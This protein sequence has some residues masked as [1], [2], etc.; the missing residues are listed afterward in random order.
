MNHHC[1]LIIAVITSLL[2]NTSHAEVYK[3]VDENGKTH[4]SDRKP[5]TDNASEVSDD[6]KN[7]NVTQSEPVQ[8]FGEQHPETDAEKQVR[9]Q[10]ER[11]KL[12]AAANREKQC[13]IARTRLKKI[14][15]PVYFQRPD[16][17][18]FE[19]TEEERAKK[20]Q[21]LSQ[22]IKRFCG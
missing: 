21:Q 11:E 9:R 7:V 12:R 17:S 10:K 22:A 15:G 4:F 5:E 20:E 14:S 1:L 6:L 19:I 13:S 3:W 16:G 8:E 18:T 2:A